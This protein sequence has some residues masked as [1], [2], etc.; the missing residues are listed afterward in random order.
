M[1]TSILKDIS[2][3]GFLELSFMPV[4]KYLGDF[5]FIYIFLLVVSG[6]FKSGYDISL[7]KNSV[8]VNFK[9]INVMIFTILFVCSCLCLNSISIEYQLQKFVLFNGLCYG[10]LLFWMIGTC[11]FVRKDKI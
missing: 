6:V 7:L 5:N 3:V 8:K 10:V 9:I 2:Y 1:N 4:T 11:Y